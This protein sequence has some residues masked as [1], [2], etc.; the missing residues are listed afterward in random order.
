MKIPFLVILFIVSLLLSSCDRQTTSNT[1]SAAQQTTKQGAH[2]ATYS[3]KIV[4]AR[5]TD[6][7]GAPLLEMTFNNAKRRAIL[8]FRGETI[9]VKQDTTASGIRYSNQHYDYREWHGEIKLK[10]DGK[11]VFQHP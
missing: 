4:H 1:K 9:E 2:D 5:V 6:K 11:I 8:Y 10:K 7:S 3:D